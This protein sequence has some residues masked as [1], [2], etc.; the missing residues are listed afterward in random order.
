[1][2]EYKLTPASQSTLAED[3]PIL[4]KHNG[5]WEGTY[6]YYTA[7]GKLVGEHDSRLLCRVMT[8]G[9]YAYYQTNIYTYPDGRQEI[10]EFPCV[11]ENRSKVVVFKIGTI[12]GWVKEDH[13][14]PGNV[15]TKLYWE[16]Y[17]NRNIKFYEMIQTDPDFKH[18][19][20]V[21]QW[22]LDGKNILRTLINE[23]KVSDTWEEYED[24]DRTKI[25]V[26]DNSDIIIEQ[27]IGEKL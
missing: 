16:R 2:S 7:D 13:D 5:V 19:T 20:R 11:Y 17:G 18:R 24:Y 25:V 14:M 27:L 10:K 1:M 12:E 3:M 6:R 4:A 15:S 21:W 9:D 22:L 8:E 26:E 23:T